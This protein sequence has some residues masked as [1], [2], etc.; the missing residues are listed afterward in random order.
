MMRRSVALHKPAHAETCFPGS[1]VT[2]SYRH[3]ALT[4]RSCQGARALVHRQRLL[5]HSC[6]QPTCVTP[7]ANPSCR[8][9][10]PFSVQ[11]L[12]NFTDADTTLQENYNNVAQ[13]L[14]TP[15]A[16]WVRPACVLQSCHSAVVT[17]LSCN[18][19]AMEVQPR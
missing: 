7:H 4:H 2:C 18:M 1:Y 9:V 5:A 11:A 8:S 12:Y 19:A 16:A 15:L 10:S 13:A 17:G 6:W 3:T 14:L